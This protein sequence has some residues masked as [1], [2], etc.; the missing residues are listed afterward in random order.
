MSSLCKR[1]GVYPPEK[2]IPKFNHCEK[3]E[4]NYSFKK[5]TVLDFEQIL[6]QDL[7]NYAQ[8]GA[9]TSLENEFRFS[10]SP[11]NKPKCDQNTT[12]QNVYQQSSK[13]IYTKEINKSGDGG[14][15]L[16]ALVEELS[17]KDSSHGEKST[18]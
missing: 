16:T 10:L 3:A 8:I 13:E 1:D 7:I 12:L 11:I 14:S 18:L 9:L 2:H 5:Q 17:T 15:D 6:D 4:P